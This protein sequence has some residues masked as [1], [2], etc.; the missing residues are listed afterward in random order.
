MCECAECIS[1]KSLRFLHSP[2]LRFKRKEPE[3]VRRR[4][5]KQSSQVVGSNARLDR[6]EH[7]RSECEKKISAN[8]AARMKEHLEYE[9][10]NPMMSVGGFLADEVSDFFEAASL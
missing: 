6:E 4:V 9:L 5:T 2:C 3:V 1:S 7:E 8:S 10:A